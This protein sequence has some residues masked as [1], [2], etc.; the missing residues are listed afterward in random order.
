MTEI[1]AHIRSAIQKYEPV[2]VDGLTFYPIQVKNRKSFWNASPAIS[3]MQQTLPV[4][5]MRIPLL[6]AYF[7]MDMD[8]VAEQA[9]T[10][11]L[12]YRGLLFLALAL[13]LGEGQS[14]EAR[15]KRFKVLVDREQPKKL[16]A[17]RFT[18][19]GEEMRELTP[20]QFQQIRSILAAQNGIDLESD[21]ANPELVEAE[22]DSNQF[23][24]PKLD[25]NDD[26]MISF[27]AALSHAEEGEIEEWPILKLKRRERTYTHLMRYLLCGVSE[28]AGGSWKDGN[29]VPHPY[30]ERV[31]TVSGG[32][33]RLDEVVPDAAQKAVQNP[34]EKIY[35]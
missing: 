9:E 5:L 15:V 13:R 33:R 21:D 24:A 26:A 11:G 3:F 7:K 12:F 8:A 31:K 10:F 19:N 28:A 17:V 2:T 22:R 14:D 6:S 4:S 1:P 20:V 30:Y 29:P 35:Q 16:A 25:I 32:L 23:K 34:G 18:V 27:V